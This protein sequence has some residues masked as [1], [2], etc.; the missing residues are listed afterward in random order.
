MK[1]SPASSLST[2]DKDGH[3]SYE[4]LKLQDSSFLWHPSHQNPEPIASVT[5]LLQV[6]HA[7]YHMGWS[8]LMKLTNA[9]MLKQAGCSDTEDK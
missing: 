1:P 4:H 9:Q 5:F 8:G 6:L 3:F 2:S 7:L